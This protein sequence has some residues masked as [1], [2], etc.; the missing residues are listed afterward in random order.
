MEWLFVLKDKG[1]SNQG[2]W[3]KLS[4]AEE[5]AAYVEATHPTR[6]GNVFENYAYGKEFNNNSKQHAPHM[7]EE[8]ITHAVVQYATR[9]KIP[10]NILQAIQGFAA[11]IAMQQLETIEETGCIYVN[12]VGGYHGGYEGE[13]TYGFVRRKQLVF[14]DFTKDNIRV[15]RYQDGQHF[16]AFIDDTQVRD[17]DTLK[18]D[19]YDEA[20]KQSLSYISAC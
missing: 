17:G 2:W 14:P 7:Q 13:L 9:Q 3:L 11:D 5:L 12:R 19:T 18:W 4:S 1:T 16:Y 20:Y 10:M 8:P 6:Y 15:R